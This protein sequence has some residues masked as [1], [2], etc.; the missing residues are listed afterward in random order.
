MIEQYFFICIYQILFNYLEAEGFKS[1]VLFAIDKLFSN[2]PV[3]GSH[4]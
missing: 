2:G 4:S 3:L 1:L